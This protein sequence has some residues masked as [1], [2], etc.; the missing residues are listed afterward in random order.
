MTVARYQKAR[1]VTRG[2]NKARYTNQ[3][4]VLRGT[5]TT[6]RPT[7][8]SISPT[9]AVH[10]AANIT[11]TCT[12]TLFVSGATKVTFDGIDQPTTFVSA[13]SV[14]APYPLASVPAAKVVSVNVRN[15]TLLSTTPRSL[16]IT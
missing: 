14:T 16:T 12:G 11:I 4:I 13:T 5:T 7:L 6:S 8:A 15:N 2:A 9:T 3:K 10:G 1:R